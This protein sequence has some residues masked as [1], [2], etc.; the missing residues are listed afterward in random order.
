MLRSPSHIIS[1]PKLLPHN[2]ILQV[3]HLCVYIWREFEPYNAK[4]TDILIC[5]PVIFVCRL[6]VVSINTDGTN[7]SS[8]AN[9]SALT[10][11]NHRIFT[12]KT[13]VA[14][15][16]VCNLPSDTSQT[17]PPLFALFSTL[18]SK[19]LHNTRQSS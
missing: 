7:Y 1:P 8:T 15:I 2:Y 3:L 6:P 14:L 16:R 18:S 19:L 17:R 4:I 9:S 10:N 11:Q 12:I 5:V 13:S